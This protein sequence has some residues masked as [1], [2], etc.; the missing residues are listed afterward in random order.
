MKLSTVLKYLL[1]ATAL[2]P[3]VIFSQYIS[4]FHFGKGVIF[5]PL[6]EIMLALYL[7]LIWKDR[8]YLPR[9][10]A[11]FWAV[12]GFALAFTIATLT[13]VNPYISMWGTLER[14]GGLFAFWHY[15]AFFMILISI[16]RTKEDWFSFLRVSVGVA[17]LS[18]LY[19]FG[20]RTDIS[21]FI[22]SGGRERIFGTIGNPALFAGYELLNVFLAVILALI[23]NR[24]KER[25]WL[26]IAAGTM[27]IA[28]S[29]TAVRGSI[30]GLAVGAIVFAFLY[31]EQT[32]SRLARKVFIGLVVLGLLFVGFAFA[33][34]NSS[35]VKN[36]P[37]LSRVTDFSPSAYTVQTR[38]WAWRA[39]LK[40][41][42]DSAKHMV[43]GWGPENFNVP[44]SKNFN[45]EFFKGPGS[46]TLFDRAHNMFI[47]ILVTMG[48][49][50]EIAYLA[51]FAVLFRILWRL[52]KNPEYG[53]A[54]MGLIG[55]LIAYMIHNALIFDT[56]ANFIVFFTIL[57]FISFMHHAVKNEKSLTSQIKNVPNGLR[58]AGAV[59]LFAI[60]GF[61]VY[62]T[63]ILP[64][65]ANYAT[66]R[67]MIAG[68]NNDFAGAIQSFNQATQFNGPGRYEF[69]N[70]YAQ[71]LLDY[72]STSQL[73]P[74]AVE[75]FKQVIALEEKNAAEN[76]EDYLPELYLSRLNIILGQSDPK[77]PYNDVALQHSERALSYSPTFVRTYYEVGQAYLNKKDYPNAEAAFKKAYD[78]N[79][80]T[81]ISAWY[82]GS[83]YM[84]AGDQDTGLK[85]VGI[86]LQKGYTLS[87]NDYLSLAS[88]YI[89]KNDF[90]SLA[91]IYEGLIAVAPNNAQYHA[92]LAVT[93]ARIGRID[94][95]VAQA[96]AA[97][98][99]DPSFEVEAK[100]FVQ[101]LGRQW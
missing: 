70:Q 62:K 72:S 65:R 37:Y 52:K 49:I 68:F 101:Q 79:P 77:S 85:Y 41:W 84:Q 8:S 45:P 75:V 61:S 23:S 9:I 10:N 73:T 14:M 36:S 48:L 35:L 43:L 11:L 76:Q 80:N 3:L 94:D 86:A 100:K 81:S 67:G 99:V 2:V 66:T 53:V 29:M 58:W 90:Q 63:D 30:L 47:E 93:Y 46:E 64:A 38:T 69:R 98:S 13:S 18:A 51:L 7:L 95:A 78:L 26:F 1:Y 92:S 24:P 20:Q 74:Q 4:P 25:A 60:I 22:G 91:K 54:A 83:V 28:L 27:S 34:R 88:L 82:L 17:F 32:H 87:E 59:L 33:F 15:V 55:G 40:G 6:V 50:G 56:T 57:G 31:F 16:L 97:V 12:I 89:K 44:F 39:G 19:G 5:K 71:F 42:S 96:R 21:F